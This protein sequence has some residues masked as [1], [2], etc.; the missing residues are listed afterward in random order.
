M[1]QQLVVK[2][3]LDTVTKLM[4]LRGLQTHTLVLEVDTEQTVPIQ[5]MATLMLV[6]HTDL[7]I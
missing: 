6:K 4:V 5:E 1:V 7:P 2:V 3:E